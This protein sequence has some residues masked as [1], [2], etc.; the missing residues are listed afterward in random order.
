MIK[1]IHKYICIRCEKKRQSI[2]ENINICRKC[3]SWSA[4]GKGQT[5]FM[6]ETI[7]K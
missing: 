3:K 2:F 1:E 7:E 4:P 5:S 6:G